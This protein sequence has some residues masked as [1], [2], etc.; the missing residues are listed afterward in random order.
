MTIIKTLGTA[1]IIASAL[2]GPAMAQQVTNTGS[3]QRQASPDQAYRQNGNWQ[4]SYNRWDDRS[5]FRAGNAA[6]GTAS[7]MAVEPIGGEEYARR[8]GFVCIPGTLFRGED[9]RRHICQ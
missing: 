9:G 2:A 5:G 6:A 7:A 3:Y 1:A 8:N 4:N